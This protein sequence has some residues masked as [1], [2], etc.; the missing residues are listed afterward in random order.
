[1]KTPL[2][3]PSVTHWC[4]Q[5]VNPIEIF[6][7]TYKNFP[8]WTLQGGGGRK[9]RR[10]GGGEPLY[11]Y[12]MKTPL[13]RASVTHR[14]NQLVNPIEIFGP[15]YKNFPSW[16]LQGGGGRK[17]RRWG[18]GES[19]YIFTKWKHLW[20]GQ[21]WHKD[22]INLSIQ[23]KFLIRL[24]KIFHP[25]LCKGEGVGRGGDGEEE[26]PYIFTKWKHL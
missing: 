16:T 21:V 18:G 17:R 3:R 11:F 5:L 8:S 25:G 10:W 1:M 15:T 23:L 20:N 12:K 14:C 9:R 26:S 24:T 7:L 4:N 19:P 6:D 22:V 2:K 13:K